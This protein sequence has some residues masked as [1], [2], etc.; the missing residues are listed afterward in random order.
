MAA[1]AFERVHF[2]PHRRA[3][4]CYIGRLPFSTT[5][6]TFFSLGLRYE[7]VHHRFP[8]PIPSLLFRIRLYPRR[9][10]FEASLDDSPQSI[11]PRLPCDFD[12]ACG[13]RPGR[14]HLPRWLPTTTTTATPRTLMARRPTIK[15]IMAFNH[16][17]RILRSLHS[18]QYR[19]TR[20]RSKRAHTRWAA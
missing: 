6:T 9:L 13:T 8:T 2:I 3:V 15:I 5:T 16:T 1:E 11:I 19:P 4:L 18:L 7:P 17:T 14:E 10:P 20:L 12:P